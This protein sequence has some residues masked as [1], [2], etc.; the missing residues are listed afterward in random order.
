MTDPDEQEPPRPAGGPAPEEP[1]E[2]DTDPRAGRPSDAAAADDTERRLSP[3]TVLTASINYAKSAVLPIL[4]ALVAGDFNPWVLGGSAVAL[5]TLLVSGYVTYRT[6]RYRVNNERLEIRSGLVSRSRRT[7]PLERIRGVDVT[8][9]LLHR[10]VGLA[11]VRIDAA[12]GGAVKQEEAKLDAV[13]AADAERLR[14]ELL[15]RRSLRVARTGDEAAAPEETSATD[16]EHP[17]PDTSRD[18]VHFRMPPRWYRYAVLSPGYLLTPFAVLATLFGFLNQIIDLDIVEDYVADQAD[19]VQRLVDSGWATL[20]V[21]A[22]GAV[23]LLAVAMPLFA[24]ASYMINQWRFTL[25]RHGDALV[26]ERGLFTRHSVT[27]EYR[28]IHGHELKDNPV[29]RLRSL[30]RLSAIV[31]GLGEAATRATL[32]PLGPRS[33]VEAVV[34]RA[35]R[36]YEGELTAHPAAARSRRLFRAVV[37]P[38]AAAAAAAAL[39]WHW[40]AGTLLLVALLGVPLGLDRYRS[41]G[42][43]Y[44]GEQVSVRSGS[45]SRSQATVARSA[46]IGWRWQQSLFQRRAGLAT[47]EVT[48]GAGSGSY[49]A[50]DADFAESVAF[51]HGVTPD[52]VAP[53]LAADP[54]PA[55][56]GGTGDRAGARPRGDDPPGGP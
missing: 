3:L 32:L 14:T 55:E 11:V 51:A 23:V 48:V 52:M 8:S 7:I 50:V 24:V 34:A 28:R 5:V 30:V 27:L 47:L 26:T 22:T 39:G 21:V 37:P 20:L 2:A 56:H 36:R 33:E 13:T 45:L 17:E 4:V 31:T 53:F 41:L 54:R 15:R 42:H 46:V 49:G 44:D 43:G 19:T 9:T 35:L 12:A 16:G 18:V 1:R 40:V 6:V 38:L 25:R 10:L 29:Q